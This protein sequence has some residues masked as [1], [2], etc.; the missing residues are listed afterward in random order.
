[1][2]L[3][4]SRIHERVKSMATQALRREGPE[5]TLEP[6]D[7]VHEVFLRLHGRPG[8]PSAWRNRAHFFGSVARSISQVL[9]DRGRARRADRR[10]GGVRPVPL[11]E[12]IDEGGLGRLD[13][14]P[15]TIEAI[16]AALDEL[17]RVSPRPGEIAWM[18]LV[19]GLPAPQVAETLGLGLRTVEG[20]W[21]FA[22]AWL[23]V[24]LSGEG[25]GPFGG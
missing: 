4:W 6:T 21:A 23:R 24:R 10:G 5:P 11:H 7:L 17:T 25:F 19:I 12:L 14:D 9:I 2:G 15:A 8:R 13:D 3:L 1:M 20:D 22:R 16:H 18:R